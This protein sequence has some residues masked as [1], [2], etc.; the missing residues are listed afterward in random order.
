MPIGL[1]TVMLALRY[2]TESRRHGARRTLDIA[3]AATV[4][5]GVVV[6]VYVIVKA[7]TYRWDSARTLGL[8]GEALAL[9]AA[10]VAIERRG[11]APLMRLS[12]LRVRSLVVGDAALLCMF[13]MVFFASLYV[14]EILGYSPLTTGIAFLPVTIALI[15]ASAASPRLLKRFSVRN[16]A[17]VGSSLAA[18]GSLVLTRLPVH[19]SYVDDVLIGLIPFSIGAGLALVPLTGAGHQRGR[20]HGVGTGGRPV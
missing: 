3:G 12:I 20:R 4:T 6:L 9:L 19:G 10:F 14:Q 17:I 11:Q 15:L 7:Q 1:A 5:G 2:V 18:G 8:A 13:G 16:V